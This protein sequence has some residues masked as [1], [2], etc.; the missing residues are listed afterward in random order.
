MQAVQGQIERTVGVPYEIIAIDNASARYG[1]CQAYNQGAAQSQHPCLCFMHEDLVF[2]EQGWGG[3]VIEALKDN[4]LGLLGI[5]GS[6]A[7]SKAPSGWSL[8]TDLGITRLNF[9]QRF[10]DGTSRRWLINPDNGVLADVV[11]LDGCWLCTRREV[12]QQIPFDEQTFRHFHFYD[13]DYSLQIVQAG[14]RACVLYGVSIE[15]LSVGSLNKEWVREAL[16]FNNKWKSALPVCLPEIK[17]AE[18]TETEFRTYKQFV[19]RLIRN[20][21]SRWITLKYLLVCHT[22]GRFDGE[23]RALW[24][25]FLIGKNINPV[26]SIAN[27]VKKLLASSS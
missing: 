27:K 23:L 5:M 9:I 17:P 21:Y 11:T 8:A 19:G 14:Y 25:L 6:I 13:L 18:L 15:H 16:I 22:F 26:A 2:H 4:R 1:I 3:K 7:K 10:L 24:S 12:W 20:K